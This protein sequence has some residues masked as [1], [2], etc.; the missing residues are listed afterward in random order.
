MPKLDDYNELL[1]ALGPHGREMVQSVWVEAARSFEPAGL[2]HYLQ[3]AREIATAGLGWSVMLA[4]LR[5]TPAIARQV[6]ERAAIR[7]IDV[8]LSVYA[9]TDA[10]IAEQVFASG[11]VAARRLNDQ[12]LFAVYLDFLCELAESAPAGIAPI[13]SRLDD[14]LEQLG[15]DGL[16][17]WAML[18]VQSHMRDPNAQARYF[19]LDSVEGRALL[20]AEGDQTV[21]A[22]IERRISLYLRALWGRDMK[23]RPVI[24]TKG[25]SA[26]RRSSIEGLTIRLPQAYRGFA[27]QT[28]LA[29]YRAAAAHAA[30]HIMFTTQRFPVGSLKPLQVALVSLIED[31]RVEQLAIARFPGLR[32]LWKTFHMAQ[33]GGAITSASLMAR[34]ARALI[35]EEFT[36]DDPWVSKGRRLFFEQRPYWE[37]QSMS[38]ALG[39]L[40]G[41]DMGQMRVQFNFKTYVVEP[42][43]RDDNQGVWDFGDMGEPTENDEDVVM[44]GAR[45]SDGNK[46]PEREE[47]E[48]TEP[49]PGQEEKVK[50]TAP[51][52]ESEQLL[53]EALS[54]P[55]RYDEWDYLIGRERPAW[56]T[57][58]EK[59]AAEGS[60]HDIADILERN[61]ELL[62][63]LK[64]LVK[65]VQV[66]RPMR[67]N[68][69]LDGDR[70]D[71][72]ACIN[73]TIDLRSGVPPDPRVHAILGRQ[74]RDLSVLVLLDLSHSTND[75]VRN[76]DA[77]VLSLAREAT[78]LLAE[79]MARIGDSFAIHGFCS[80]GRHDVGYYR[81]KDF[82]RPYGELAKSRL[83]AMSGQLST[84]MGTAL[85]HA[86][87]YLKDRRAHK[88]LIL[89]VTDGEPSDI[90]VHDRQ[91]LMFDA[92]KAVE[93]NNRH[94]IFTYCMSLDPNA[95]RYVSRIFGQRNYMVVDHVRRLPEKLPMLYMR[96]TN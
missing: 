43:Y 75:K 23:L 3:G 71:L 17:R 28:G 94:G 72:N 19:Q 58:L 69:R 10:R 7:M 33:S 25:A 35:D 62:N 22:D 34:L 66:Q 37:D 73:A 63:R 96:V 56:C 4:Y 51:S 38:R 40:L 13:L 39:G 84:R 27:G 90:D 16:R 46:G 32:G 24:H 1:E 30:A 68:K 53:E 88:K 12:A 54:P 79:A 77:T 83:A 91:Y 6:G 52:T 21:F 67:L 65:A 29:L 42:A 70:L 85:R 8:A 18:G 15:L 9:R 87:A 14:L 55:I 31:A 59:P 48:Q 11:V 60:A 61:E 78:A 41:N 81:F 26:G 57:L 49:P 20:Q 5:E 36:D 93:E 64:V 74:Q 80:N 95:D 45:L 76:A 2:T 47:E 92:K 50:L 44:Q 86:G 82:E 89:L